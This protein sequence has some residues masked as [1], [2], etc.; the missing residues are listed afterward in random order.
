M[1]DGIGTGAHV[2]HKSG[3]TFDYMAV[4]KC[5]TKRAIADKNAPFDYM[6]PVD[7]IN[8]LL[9]YLKDN[10]EVTK[11]IGGILCG[12]TCTSLSSQGKR[13]EWNGESKI[14]FECVKV[15]NYV[16]SIV[17]DVKIFFE[18]VA[19]M[20]TSCK[21]R[22][23]KELGIDCYTLNA[24]LVSGQARKRHYWFNWDKKGEVL[25][26]GILANDLLDDDALFLVAFSKS[27][28]GNGIVEGRQRTDGKASTLVTGKGCNGQSTKNMVIT[29]KMKTR[30]LSI[31][32]IKRLQ[33]L[34]FF[35]FSGFSNSQIEEAIGDGWQFN[36]V[37]EIFSWLR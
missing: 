15:V 36:A 30:D 3:A 22:I 9:Q 16:K 23:S 1:A 28:R 10:P 5:S 20:R 2:L 21:N 37:M 31:N 12:F 18:N 11:R 27:H 29:K 35:D 6:R 25:D 8:D 26:N 7:D 24:G 19:S 17:P 13:E 32:E 33:G 34:D 14:F 4:E